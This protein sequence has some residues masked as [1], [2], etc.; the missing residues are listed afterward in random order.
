MHA[1]YA[2]IILAY[3]RSVLMSNIREVEYSSFTPLVLSAKGGMADKAYKDFATK[4]DSPTL[5]CCDAGWNSRY[6]AQL[7]SDGLE[8]PVAAVLKQ[9]SHFHPLTWSVQER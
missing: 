2:G 9:L 5:S 1:Y 3:L 4:W 8:V 6:F 7:P